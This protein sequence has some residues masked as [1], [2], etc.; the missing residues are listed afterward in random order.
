M[1][2]PIPAADRRNA[3]IPFGA[4]LAGWGLF[5]ILVGALGGSA[6]PEARPAPDAGAATVTATALTSYVNDFAGALDF[7]ARERLAATLQQFEKETSNQLAV[8]I[9]PRLPDGAVEDFTIKVAEL[10]RLGRKGLDNGA[11]LSVFAAE[12][13]ARIEV[14]YGLE[15]ALTDAQTHRILESVFA[16]AW[17]AGD[18]DK[19]MDAT[20]A[21]MMA[22][23]REEYR[24]GKMPGR[25]AI[26]W[27]ALMT[28]IPKLAKEAL[29]AL[30]SVPTEGRIVLSLFGTLFLLGFWDG[31]V[32]TRQLARNAFTAVGNLRA[33]RGW[34]R[35]TK[36]VQLGSVIDAM[37]ITLFLLAAFGLGVGVVV[38]AG[39]G[40]FGS[41]GAT[42]HW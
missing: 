12:K 29:P 34:T 20:L 2:K 36:A 16:P 13:V 26:F 38:V 4:V 7:A 41:A 21:A 28:A 25:A 40:A 22:A 8:A 19:A 15:G 30:A 39:G 11:V 3:F 6:R 24:A 1:P 14:G 5:W 42:L 31:F 35:G 18:R 17:R 10:S 9:Y 23:V 32:Q 33:G 37:K 27:R